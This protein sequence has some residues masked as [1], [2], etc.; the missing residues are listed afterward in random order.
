MR[1]CIFASKKKVV[2][3]DKKKQDF[4]G[5]GQFLQIKTDETSFLQKKNLHSLFIKSNLAKT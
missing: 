4:V 2:K 3:K 5:F 1:K